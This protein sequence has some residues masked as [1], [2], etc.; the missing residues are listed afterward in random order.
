MPNPYRSHVLQA[1]LR[2]AALVSALL[3]HAALAQA[4]ARSCLS[5]V[6]PARSSELVKQCQEVSPA[7][8]PPCN[9]TN[10]CELIRSEI[11]RGC[12]ILGADAPPLCEQHTDIDD[13][14]ED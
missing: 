1:G 3:P 6:G 13:D 8:R 14:A 4:P 7:T 11:R 2:F 10:S 5:E 9:A 12:E